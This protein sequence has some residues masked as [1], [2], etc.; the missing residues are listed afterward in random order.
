ML[1][2]LVAVAATACGGRQS[3]SGG[4]DAGS[5]DRARDTPG[6]DRNADADAGGGDGSPPACT[7]PPLGA[8]LSHDWD[9]HLATVSGTMTLAGAALPDSPG[10]STRGNLTFASSTPVICG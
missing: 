5:A 4:V 6:T 8:D 2:A 7:L 3:G 10:L 9:L 1:A